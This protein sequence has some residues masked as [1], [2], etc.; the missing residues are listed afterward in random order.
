M[1]PIQSFSIFEGLLKP[2]DLS[3]RQEQHKKQMALKYPGLLPFE[4]NEVVKIFN[5]IKQRMPS[6][7]GTFNLSDHD[8]RC[9]I[10]L[11]YTYHNSNVPNVLADFELQKNNDNM[12]NLNTEIRTNPTPEY[13]SPSKSDLT[14]QILNPETNLAYDQLNY[15][16]NKCIIKK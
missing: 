8:H 11:G 5:T 9:L 12:Y 3:G 10:L 15:A 7:R 14:T 6:T 13:I 1:K 16:I 2:R 4:Y